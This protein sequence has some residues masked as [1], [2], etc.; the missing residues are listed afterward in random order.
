MSSPEHNAQSAGEPDHLTVWVVE[1]NAA[2]RQALTRLFG[3]TPGVVCSHLFGNAEQLL[4]KLR[5][6]PTSRS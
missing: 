6:K 4:A 5:L 2:Y 3:R 1:D